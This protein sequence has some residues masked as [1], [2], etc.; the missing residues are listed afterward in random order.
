MEERLR[1]ALIQAELHWQ[2]PA[3]NRRHLGRLITAL[4]QP[5]DLYILPETFTTGFLGRVGDKP[6]T[7]RGETLDWMAALAERSQAAIAG[8]LA[9]SDDEG[10]LRN[11]F[12]WVQADGSRQWYDKRHLFAYAG[13]D[14]RYVAGDSRRT[15]AWQGWRVCPQICYDLRF[16]VWCRNRNDYDL[17]IFVANWPSPRV[18]AWTTLLK[19]RAME[20]QCYVAG[21]N[22]VGLDG[23]G[24]A[25][26]GCSAIYDPLG[27]PV[28]ELG[29]EETSA[30]GVIDYRVLTDTRQRFP[31][32]AEADSFQIID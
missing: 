25:Y 31:F 3:E 13:E 28:V 12:V 18:D 10:R 21:V 20:N 14:Q 17:L 1:L 29:G 15:W 16:P 5:A 4:D 27:R 11:R 7:M 22:R 8:S 30:C 23:H 6:D 9:L 24:N 19:A 2:H 32:Q 26:P